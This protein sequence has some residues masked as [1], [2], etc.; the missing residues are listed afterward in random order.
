LTD[1]DLTYPL[2]VFCAYCRDHALLAQWL[3]CPLWRF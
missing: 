3:W 1:Q 2:Y